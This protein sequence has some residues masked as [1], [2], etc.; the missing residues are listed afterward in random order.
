MLWRHH[1]NTE[2]IGPF[3]RIGISETIRPSE[4]LNI[5]FSFVD[6]KILEPFLFLGWRLENLFAALGWVTFL[7]AFPTR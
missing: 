4:T 2:T 1:R 5:A 7:T 3:E 6:G